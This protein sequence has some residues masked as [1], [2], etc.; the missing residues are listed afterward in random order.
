MP[1]GWAGNVVVRPEPELAEV[2]ANSGPA[3]VQSRSLSDTI[4]V[5]AMLSP[6]RNQTGL[7]AAWPVPNVGP[8]IPQGLS[9]GNKGGNRLSTINGTAARNT[10]TTISAPNSKKPTRDSSLSRPTTRQSRHHDHAPI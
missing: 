3:R 6:V 1:P 7:E 5:S 9:A 4:H 2:L 8:F 10:R